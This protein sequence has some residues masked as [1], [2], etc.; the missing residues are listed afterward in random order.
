MTS[1]P[2]AEESEV[3]EKSRTPALVSPR[4]VHVPEPST[5]PVLANQIDPVFNDT[6]TYLEHNQPSQNMTAAINPERGGHIPDET[7]SSS[8]YGETN[9]NI[10]NEIGSKGE[11]ADGDGDV[12]DDY[13][14][15][16]DFDDDETLENGDSLTKPNEMTTIDALPLPSPDE[17]ENIEST[18]LYSVAEV[19]PGNLPAPK[20][21]SH[22]NPTQSTYNLNDSVG[23][24]SSIG[25]SAGIA[26]IP[27][28]STEP[29]DDHQ[30]Q[31]NEATSTDVANGGVNFQALLD[32]LSPSTA[33]APSADGLTAA[34][35]GSPAVSVSMPKSEQA[36]SP[37]TGLPSH[38]NLP[39]R[40]PP[41]EKP[42][43]HLGFAP[44]DDIRSYHPHIPTPVGA[45]NYSTQQPSSFR[46]SH[47]L[48]TPVVAAGAPGT[49]SQP[50]SGLP[51]PPVA[52]FQQAPS[53]AVPQQASPLAASVRQREKLDR[54]VARSA[55]SVDDDDEEDQA[56]WGSEIQKIYDQFLHDERTYVTE[57]QWDRF[58]PNS[59]LF[60][61]NLPTEKV[62][63]RD[64]F[65][66][67][68][69]HG[70]L[71]QVS[72]KQAYGFVQFLDSDS[73]YRALQ[74]EQGQNV[75]GRKMH[76]EISK[77][78]KNTRNAAGDAAGSRPGPI[79][80]S[81]SPD[82]SRGGVSPM[83][84]SRAR[85]GGDRNDRGYERSGGLARD[86][87]DLRDGKRV[88]DD[89]RPQRDGSPYS[90][91][92]RD[93]YR[94]GR[95]RDDR[96][97]GNR[98]RSRS[99]PYGHGGGYRGRSP[100]NHEHEEDSELSL[101]RRSPK[102]VPDVEFIQMDD[103][104]R[105][106]VS[107]VERAFRDRGIQTHVMFLGPR[108]SLA[109]A[110]R[111]H[112]LEGVQA[113]VRLS[114]RSQSSA[115]VPL[116]V[117]DRRG[118]AD[119][120]RFDEYDDL[121]PNIAAELVLRAKQTHGAPSQNQFTAPSQGLQGPQ[122][123]QPY[124]APQQQ[125]NPHAAATAPNLA[126]LITSLDGP[127]LQ[128][129]LGTL[130]QQQQPPP[131]PHAA[132]QPQHQNHAQQQH[133]PAGLSADLASLLGGVSRPTPQ[134][135]AQSYQ[136]PQPAPNP[137]S[138]LASNP[139]FTGNPA[140]ESLLRQQQGSAPHPPHNAQQAQPAQQVQNIMEQ[141]AKW[142]Q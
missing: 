61:G 32:N 119:N 18:P 125:P 63:K 15:S 46:P 70:K 85:F 7:S 107:F 60:I 115:K 30:T 108:V 22:P 111:R 97:D 124:P 135:Q 138:S 91:R 76:L 40:P 2:R 35:T 88:R 19:L 67:F 1:S 134:Q 37:M 106:F 47:G 50:A 51:P 96:Y 6:S 33:T 49:A 72:I 92:E 54:S 58:P 140:L 86:R 71:A 20:T 74:H 104:D 16:L 81:R 131:P 31:S 26:D 52:T 77:P 75:R 10:G 83:N 110:I 122:Y 90:P 79:R 55:T 105:N 23:S 42:T 99:P 98:R 41:Q 43:S 109:A 57:G 112:I 3:F 80:R 120:V 24:S 117:F 29:R 133:P 27:L 4:P 9:N 127:T 45:S 118:G 73:C 69:K 56:P 48:P 142:K 113:V 95:D 123:G 137:F 116:Q 44:Q 121:D 132:Q 64:L 59:R 12:V 5:I 93:S 62:T 11:H 78:Q 84:G 94:G 17:T 39:P 65:H 13:A 34:T 136:Q 126:N 53:S 101:P 128:K 89:Y 68:H 21:E 141:L 100:R 139:A 130:Q 38:A 66:I 114:R 25:E 8:T 87:G 102:D 14:M 82:Y 36:K 103:L 129:L 28:A